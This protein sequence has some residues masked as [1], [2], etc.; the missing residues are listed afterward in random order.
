MIEIIVNRSFNLQLPI[1]MTLQFIEENPLLVADRIPSLY[2]LSFELPPTALNLKAFGFPNRVSSI[3][4]KRIVPAEII[5]SGLVVSRGELILLETSQSLKVQFKGSRESGNLRKEL[6][7]IDM[8]EHEYGQFP[9]NQE[10]L[11]Y[12]SPLLE[13]YTVSMRS[14]AYS[15]NPYAIAPVK[16]LGTEWEGKELK[17]GFLNAMKQYINFW[18]PSRDNLFFEDNGSAGTSR[19]YTRTPVLP[20][21]F[22]KDIINSAFG[23]TLESNPFEN[24]VDL[25]RLVTI[26]M[27]HKHNTMG[28]LLGY[29]IVPGP[30][31]RKYPVMFPLVDSYDDVDNDGLLPLKYKMQSFM[32][33]YLFADF[34]KDLMKIFCMTTFP[35]IKYKMEFNNTVMGWK[36]RVNWDDKLTGLPVFTKEE[37]KKYV[38][39]YS[40]VESSN[41]D[42]IL[43]KYSNVKAIFD[44]A[45]ETENDD[46]VVYEDE[47]TGAQYSI[48]RTL[49]GEESFVFLYSEVKNDPLATKEDDSELDK[50]EVVSRVRPATMNIQDYWEKDLTGEL[51]PRKY[52]FVPQISNTALTEAPYIMFWAGF[53]Y[54][55]DSGGITT[56]PCLLAHHTDQYG[57]KHLNTSLHPD[58]PEGLIE[59]FHG[60]MKAWVEKDKMRVKGSFRLTLL[61]IIQLKIWVKVY[62]QGRLFYIEKLDYSLTNKGVSLVDVDLIEC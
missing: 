11:D 6:N 19:A 33:Q 7:N 31:G 3:S 43:N 40:G 15:A 21:P 28:T 32:Q 47:S 51:I 27:N 45:Y 44:A 9:K 46:A 30:A 20:F 22:I 17:N 18:N 53:K 24:D 61:E 14:I 16:I 49:R 4:V 42:V 5:H 25:A 8:G 35:G 13:E 56:Y 52:W 59:K 10:D 48:T 23:E 39:K 12:T 38:F 2:T 36:E 55:F 54:T 26:A 58:G 41:K 29:Y 1:D 34:L 62:F 60:S 50:L 57:A 37:A